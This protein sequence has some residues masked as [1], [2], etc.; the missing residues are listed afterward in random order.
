MGESKSNVLNLGINY[1]IA[2]IITIIIK[3]FFKLETTGKV[4]IL[5]V[6][7][8]KYKEFISIDFEYF[9]FIT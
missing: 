4:P 8:K 6:N 5:L 3:L 2:L 1:I 9:G 7:R